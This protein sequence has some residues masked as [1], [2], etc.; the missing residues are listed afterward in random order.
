MVEQAMAILTGGQGALFRRFTSV[1]VN[2]ETAKK[3]RG[4]A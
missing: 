3:C 2:F 1:D 4:T